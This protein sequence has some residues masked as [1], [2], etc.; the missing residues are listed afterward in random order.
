MEKF[1]W[2]KC[3]YCG[4][5]INLQANVSA[6][7]TVLHDINETFRADVTTDTSD[8]MNFINEEIIN[9]RGEIYC[10]DCEADIYFEEYDPEKGYLVKCNIKDPKNYTD[11][12]LAAT[13]FSCN[14][15]FFDYF[16]VETYLENTAEDFLA[17]F[18]HS[19]QDDINDFLNFKKKIKPDAKFVKLWDHQQFKSLKEMADYIR[20]YDMEK[21]E[22]YIRIHRDFD[23]YYSIA[24][25]EEW[26]GQYSKG[27]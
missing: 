18:P 4:S 17:I 11:E 9:G 27:E 19:E 16:D 3:P 24:C 10:D 23:L 12:E 7:I 21:I 6:R 26:L 14:T 8:I 1:A 2:N 22:D 15:D 13:V 20:Q 5:P 25:A